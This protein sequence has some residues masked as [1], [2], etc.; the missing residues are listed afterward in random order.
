MELINIGITDI[1]LQDFEDGKGKIIVSNFD[2]DYNFSYYWGAMGNNTNL[3]QFIKQI[4]PD[5]FASKLTGHLQDDIDVKA[6][7]ANLRREIREFMPWYLN[8]DFQSDMR[9]SLSD[10]QNHTY[11]QESFVNGWD[12]F[13]GSLWFD[14]CDDYR[15]D[16]NEVK[17]FFEGYCEHWHLIVTKPPKE[18]Y[19]CLDLHKKLKKL[20]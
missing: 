7:F 19:W 2:Y 16:K 13:I 4:N 11:S 14:D 10:Y 18:Y 8:V 1:I 12:S 15:L 3:K 5:Y 9:R 6:T 17:S 20:F